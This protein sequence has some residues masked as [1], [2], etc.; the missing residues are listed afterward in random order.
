MGR[1]C[2]G[3]RRS[4]S[5][6]RPGPPTGGSYS[7][8]RG[9]PRP[10]GGA[11]PPPALCALLHPNVVIQLDPW[12]LKPTVLSRG[13][14]SSQISSSLPDSSSGFHSRC[15]AN[16]EKCRDP[17][18]IASLH[19]T[20]QGAEGAGLSGSDRAVRCGERALLQRRKR[21]HRVPPPR[22]EATLREQMAWQDA[23][24]RPAVL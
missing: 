11:D 10:D 3:R 5:S 9:G 20:E 8:S 19:R 24:T 4:W 6:V 12:T 17:M 23:F 22:E 14:S 1:G 13:N 15:C 16:T 2:E 7:G 18:N 21:G